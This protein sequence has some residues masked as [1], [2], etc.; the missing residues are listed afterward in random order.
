MHLQI[1]IIEDDP[2]YAE[3]LRY[4]LRRIAGVQAT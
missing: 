3:L 1:F 4:Q 2:D